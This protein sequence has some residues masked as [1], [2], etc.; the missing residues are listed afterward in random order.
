MEADLSR[1]V[2]QIALLAL[3]GILG[4]KLYRKLRGRVEKKNWEDFVEILL[5]SLASYLILS[6]IVLWCSGA[7]P[8]RGGEKGEASV[9]TVYVFQALF[10]EVDPE[11]WQELFSQIAWASLIGLGL[12]LAASYVHRFG[13]VPFL[14]RVVFA[15]KR[16]GDEDI[17][18]VFHTS[19]K[20]RWLFVRDHKLGLMYY[21]FVR[22]YSDLGKDRELVLE[23]V[24]VFSNDTAEFCY[25][26]P[27]LHVCR[28]KFDLTLEVP[29]ELGDNNSGEQEA[30]EEIK[31]GEK[32]T[33][34][35]GKSPE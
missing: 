5:F 4:S 32:G 15:T 17:W 11:D 35:A 20:V 12:G 13:V 16:T 30:E 9:G 18:D 26:V 14:G 24:D 2:I 33:C 28:S 31:N 22:H 21:G 3:P 6:A 25:S 10:K 29:A 19:L 8:A 27:V 7:A 23:N 1:F 34:T